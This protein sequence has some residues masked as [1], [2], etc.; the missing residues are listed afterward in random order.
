LADIVTNELEKAQSQ[1]QLDVDTKVTSICRRMDQLELTS[2]QLSR[3]FQVDSHE[4][5]AQFETFLKAA[6]ET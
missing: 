3:D 2:D 1:M 5:K 4:L 6:Y